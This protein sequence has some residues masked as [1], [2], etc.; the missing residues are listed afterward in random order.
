MCIE[1]DKVKTKNGGLLTRFSWLLWQ[2]QV[3]LSGATSNFVINDVRN[4]GF[5]TSQIKNSEI[6]HL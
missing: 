3:W 6:G 5:S 4:T 1:F 2:R